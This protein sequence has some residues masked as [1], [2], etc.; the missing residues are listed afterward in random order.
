MLLSAIADRD[1]K[2]NIVRSLA[3]SID[4]T[5]RNRAEAALKRAKEE[6]STYSKD[7]ER[8][9]RVQTAEITSILTYTPAV[10]YI[11]DKE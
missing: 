11:K 1:A 8:L 4:I 2:G 10:V 6:L 3:V 9:V 5:Q 7:L